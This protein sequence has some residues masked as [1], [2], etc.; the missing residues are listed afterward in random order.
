[1]DRREGIDKMQTQRGVGL[2]ERKGGRGGAATLPGQGPG[3]RSVVLVHY[4]TKR[5]VVKRGA[6]LMMW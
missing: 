4:Y 5:L 1:M 6:R 3:V 2:G